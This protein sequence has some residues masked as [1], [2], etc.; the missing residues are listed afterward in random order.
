[1]NRVTVAANGE[2]LLFLGSEKHAPTKGPKNFYLKGPSMD[3]FGLSQSVSALEESKMESEVTGTPMKTTMKT[4]MR[5]CDTPELAK[6]SVYVN[7][8]GASLKSDHSFDNSPTKDL[9]KITMD[10]GGMQQRPEMEIEE[11]SD[12]GLALSRKILIDKPTPSFGLEP[13]RKFYTRGSNQ[14]LG[15]GS[16]GDH[17]VSVSQRKSDY[18]NTPG[19]SVPTVYQVDRISECS[20]LKDEFNYSITKKSPSSQKKR[21]KTTKSLDMGQY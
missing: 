7:K 13:E 19:K 16:L 1:M 8:T 15:E 10:R 17:G 12:P 14:P 4:S 3:D 18:M 2:K 21:V 11:S 9:K 5:R 6:E 20:E